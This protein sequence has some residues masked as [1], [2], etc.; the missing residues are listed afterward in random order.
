M[1]ATYITQTDTCQQVFFSVTCHSFITGLIIAPSLLHQ[2]GVGV[3]VHGQFRVATEKT[4]F[5]MPETAIG[6]TVQPCWLPASLMEG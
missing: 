3:S 4:L 2:Q 6:K 1:R 5:A